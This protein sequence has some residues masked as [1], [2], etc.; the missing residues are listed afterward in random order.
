MVP[1]AP[2]RVALPAKSDTGRRPIVTK[3]PEGADGQ[4]DQ[5]LASF[6]FGGADRLE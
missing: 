4:V 3:L 2:L 1:D 5:V 6:A